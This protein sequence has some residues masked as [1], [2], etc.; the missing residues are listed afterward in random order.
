MKISA[1]L[2]LVL[3][4]ALFYS[5]PDDNSNLLV[6]GDF[7]NSKN[8]VMPDNWNGD[9][10]VYSLDN[11]AVSG[12]HSLKYSNS[13]PSVYKLCTQQIELKPGNNYSAGIKVKTLNIAGDDYGASFCVEWMDKNGKWLG[14]AYPTG[15]KGT[16][17][18]TEISAVVSV[19]D[20]AE[21]F[22]FCC[23]VR[24]GMTGTA[25]FDDAYIR[26]YKK[27]KMNVVMLKPVYRGLLLSEGDQKIALSVNLDDSVS[28]GVLLSSAILDS[29]GKVIH[30]VKTLLNGNRNNYEISLDASDIEN[31]NYTANVKL[32]TENGE[33][34]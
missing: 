22:V 25:W 31:G 5:F 4:A 34:H 24:K 3:F 9:T 19:P 20:N 28:K 14:G 2:V 8:G 11:V 21:K 32:M 10:K 6:N 27:N 33:L 13:D 1:V 26:P 12:N 29:S 23:Y 30:S 7:E 17:D 15:I 16:H 18:W